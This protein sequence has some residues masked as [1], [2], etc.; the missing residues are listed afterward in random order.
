MIY[1]FDGI[2]SDDLYNSARV[3]FVVGQYKIFNNYV[4]DRIKNLCRFTVGNINIDEAFSEFKSL[5]RHEDAMISKVEFE[6]FLDVV[7]T[8]AVLGKWFCYVDYSLMTKNDKA[9]IEKYIKKPSD[10]GVLVVEST[11]Y[12]DY[13]NLLNNK[14]IRGSEKAHLIQLSFPSRRIL[15]DFVREMFMKRGVKISSNRVLELF[16]MRMGR[17]YD[18]YEKVIDN[19]ASTYKGVEISY[20]DMVNILK[21][22][23][24]YNI[25]DFIAELVNP[26]KS[27]KITRKK[28][29][30]KML[31]ALLNEMTARE[32]VYKLLSKIEDLLEMRIAI[33]RGYVPV[34]VVFS[35]KEAKSRLEENNRL[36]RL[37]DYTFRR[38]AELASK[39]SLKDWL[40]MKMI[41]YS[42]T[43]SWDNVRY[44]RALHALINRYLLTTDKIL[45]II[46]VTNP[47]EEDLL[48]L[49][50]TRRGGYVHGEDE[51]T[52]LGY[53]DS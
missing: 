4:I 12:K 49:N 15:M 5:S 34:S 37:N 47:F 33:N 35:V 45:G 19:I 42:V 52:Y 23:E 16:V 51:N 11:N 24:E 7:N 44:E 43:K 25:D 38:Y 18:E 40:Y 36:R 46:G 20:K 6:T 30:H 28:K 32:L 14:A 31:E 3:L 53:L 27:R 41:L 22:V 17:G 1:K 26:V 50:L 8:P 10:N 21:G 9:K 48:P 39:T 29:I 2:L 13:K